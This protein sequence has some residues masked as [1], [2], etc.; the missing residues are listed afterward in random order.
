MCIRDRAY[1][2]S[3]GGGNLEIQYGSTVDLRAG[4]LHYP[5]TYGI[6]LAWSGRISG[7]TTT[8]SQAV[9]IGFKSD[10]AIA[11][12]LHPNSGDHG[13]F[14]TSGNGGSGTNIF[15]MEVDV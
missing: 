8:G 2:A 12:V 6:L 7:H 5:N 10:G 3:S 14:A 13:G 4:A 9:K 1:G 11:A 15:L